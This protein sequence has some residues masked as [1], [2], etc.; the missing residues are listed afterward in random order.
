MKAKH[1]WWTGTAVVMTAAIAGT[2]VLGVNI[3]RTYNDLDQGVPDLAWRQ[4]SVTSAECLGAT[5][6][7]SAALRRASSAKHSSP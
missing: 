7:T 3:Q 6:L 4:V 2:A 1:M 5:T